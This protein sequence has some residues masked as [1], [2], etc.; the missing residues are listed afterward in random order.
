MFLARGACA[1]AINKAG[2]V[3]PDLKPP[4]VNVILALL[5]FLIAVFTDSNQIVEG[6]IKAAIVLILS[7][8]MTNV[9]LNPARF[10]HVLVAT[11]V[12]VELNLLH[13]IHI[14]GSSCHSDG[15]RGDGKEGKCVGELHFFSV[16]VRKLLCLCLLVIVFCARSAI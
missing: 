13:C 4:V 9:D 15:G 6:T 5:I 8:Q 10:H 12:V 14:L 11:V 7:V 3:L 2:V 1:G 16:S